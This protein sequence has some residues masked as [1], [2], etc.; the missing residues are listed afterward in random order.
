MAHWKTIVIFFMVYIYTIICMIFYHDPSSRFFT[1]PSLF[2]Y[3][4]KSNYINI[5]KPP[6]TTIKHPILAN[7]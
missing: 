4:D 6:F 7:S 1:T 3:A 5:L 2:F